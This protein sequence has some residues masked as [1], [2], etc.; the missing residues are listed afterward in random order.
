[1]DILFNE[2]DFDAWMDSDSSEAPWIIQG[3]ADDFDFEE[4]DEFEE[5]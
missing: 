5:E 1:M 2:D 3:Y 4:F